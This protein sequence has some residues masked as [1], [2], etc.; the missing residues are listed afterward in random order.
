MYCLPSS[1]YIFDIPRMNS[2]IRLIIIEQEQ[3]ARSLALRKKN[4]AY[5][6]I[7]FYRQKEEDAL[8]LVLKSHA[9]KSFKPLP[10]SDVFC[11]RL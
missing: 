4:A 8:L 2:E 9:K 7:Y 3:A 6:F 10:N 5:F 1:T 11:G